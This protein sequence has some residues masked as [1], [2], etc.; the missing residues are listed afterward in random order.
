MIA[1]LGECERLSC[2][3]KAERFVERRDLDAGT[4]PNKFG[5][6]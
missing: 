2:F 1:V 3:G 4:T 6:M 5:A